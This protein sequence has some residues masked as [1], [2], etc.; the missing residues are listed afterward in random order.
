MTT[1]KIDF[2]KSQYLVAIGSRFNKNG[3]NIGTTEVSVGRKW[4]ILRHHYSL[5]T[6]DWKVKTFKVNRFLFG[7]EQHPLTVA[8]QLEHDFKVWLKK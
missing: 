7:Q 8:N 2:D 4:I 1:N 3:W 6:V 5:N